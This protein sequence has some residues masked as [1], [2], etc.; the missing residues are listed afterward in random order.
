[1]LTIRPEQLKAF[2]AAKRQGFEEQLNTYLVSAFPREIQAL[3][4][5]LPGIKSVADLI[6]HGIARANAY[7]LEAERDVGRFV[8]LMVRLDPLFESRRD[9]A[10]ATSILKNA[11]LTPHARIELVHEMMPRKMPLAGWPA[12]PVST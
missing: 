7:G 10:W 2:S 4:L 8:E 5:T 3:N 6:R 1:M 11:S 9:M 12:P